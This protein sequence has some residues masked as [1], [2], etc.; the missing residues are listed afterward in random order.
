[1][2]LDVYLYM[3]PTPGRETEPR[4]YVREGGQ[5]KAISR[6]EWDA[7]HPGREPVVARPIDD[8]DEQECYHANITHNLARMAQEAGVYEA[9]W[10][11]EEVGIERGADLIASLRNGLATLQSDPERFMPLSPVNGWGTYEILMRFI[12]DYLA[13]CERY[14]SARVDV[15]R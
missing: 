9:L 4:I 5:T 15:S 11:P 8:G 12:A 3:P 7:R 13:A 1:V 6:T 10:R 14:P 2:S